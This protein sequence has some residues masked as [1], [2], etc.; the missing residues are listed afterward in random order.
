MKVWLLSKAQ[1]VY[2]HA[3]KTNQVE[4]SWQRLATFTIGNCTC[5]ENQLCHFVAH[6]VVSC[7]SLKVNENKGKI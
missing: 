5:A 3:C 4:A 2:V 1:T 7:Q 6:E